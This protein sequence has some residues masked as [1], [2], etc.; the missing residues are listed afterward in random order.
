MNIN[1]AIEVI[2]NIDTLSIN[3]MIAG[4]NVDMVIKN[5]VIDI[6]KQIDTQLKPRVSEVAV[7]FYEIYKDQGLSFEEWFG[8]FY[9]KEAEEDFPRLQE[10]TAWLY[11][12][13]DEVNR[14]R[15]LALATLIVNGIDAVE[16]EK[17]KKYTVRMKNV[18]HGDLGYSFVHGG[19]SF[20]SKEHNRSGIVYEFT[21]SKLDKAGFSGVFD[22]SMFEVKEVE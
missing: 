17:E 12:N 7:E 18:Y 3:D 6:L 1:E 13:S 8:D 2:N 21:K 19:Y 4:Q 11:D 14:Q 9:S 16:I 20:Y 22:N 5:Q 15:E 10:L